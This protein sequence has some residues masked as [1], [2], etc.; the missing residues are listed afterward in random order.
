MKHFK[1]ISFLAMVLGWIAQTLTHILWSIWIFGNAA[2]GDLGVVLFWSSFFILVF[3]GLFILIPR[4]GIIRLAEGT[5]IFLFSL[6]SGCYSLIGFTLLIGWAFLAFG[7]FLGVFLDAFFCGLVFGVAF[8][9]FWNHWR[10]KFKETHAFTILL[11]PLLFLLLFLVAFPKLCPS[12]A[13]PFMPKSIR[14]EIL[15]NTIPK[16]KLGDTLSDLQKALPGEFE[17]EDCHGSQGASLENFQY[18]IEVNCCKIVRIEY[19]PRQHTGY[20]MGGL[21]TPCDE[22]TGTKEKNSGTNL[23][24]ALM[25]LEIGCLDFENLWAEFEHTDYS[26]SL[27]DR[28]LEPWLFNLHEKD[29]SQ[30]EQAHGLAP[31]CKLFENEKIVSIAFVDLYDYKSALHLFTFSKPNME[32]TS[33]FLFYV[34][35]GDGEDFWNMAPEKSGTLTYRVLEEFG[36]DNSEL[37]ADQVLIKERSVKEYTINPVLGTLDKRV[38]KTEHN[39][40]EY[41]NRGPK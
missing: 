34:V 15:A 41:R 31:K 25:E 32:P 28:K 6:V 14:H 21:P 36:Y 16:F 23:K 10:H 27:I 18:V 22:T 12:Y 24:T 26:G 19:G 8:H 29:S 2:G 17:F 40:K 4:K 7:G 39:L 9:L 30:F 37:E 13:Y 20:T 5:N 1:K 3:S 35:G 38:L 33:S 11:S